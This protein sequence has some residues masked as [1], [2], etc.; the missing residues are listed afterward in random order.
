VSEEAKEQP[1]K[2]PEKRPPFWWLPALSTV[3]MALILIF[4]VIGGA[5]E[6]RHFQIVQH[7]LEERQMTLQNLARQNAHL[8]YTNCLNGKIVYA[9]IRWGFGTREE[10]GKN[11]ADQRLKIR[12]CAATQKA[13]HNV[14]L[15]KK[16]QQYVIDSIIHD[17]V[18]PVFDAKERIV[19]YRS[20]PDFRPTDRPKP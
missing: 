16:H 10:G 18:L 17:A 5:K 14:Y 7:Q 9:I 13:G 4:T 8:L 11:I 2:K 20:V 19:G 3:I 15:S 1:E 6:Q 12:N